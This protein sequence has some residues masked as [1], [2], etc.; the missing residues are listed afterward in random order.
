MEEFKEVK[1]EIERIRHHQDLQKKVNEENTKILIEI[2]TALVGSDMNDN[3]GIVSQNKE[4]N[5]RLEDLE[6]FKGEVS[7]YVKQAKFVIGA[8]A[9]VLISIFV[10]LFNLKT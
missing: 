7:V 9:V 1:A 3:K 6:E 4:T 8:L 10:K 5:L 2:K